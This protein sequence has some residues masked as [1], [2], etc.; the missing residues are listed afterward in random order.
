[1]MV[2]RLKSGEGVDEI[3]SSSTRGYIG[4]QLTPATTTILGLVWA[5]DTDAKSDSSDQLSFVQ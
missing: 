3:S 4:D 5:L 2:D 1:M